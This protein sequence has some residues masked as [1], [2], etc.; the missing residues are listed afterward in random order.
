MQNFVGQSN[1]QKTI[2]ERDIRFR[3]MTANNIL[4]FFRDDISVF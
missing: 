4:Q 1:S 2:I 3:I